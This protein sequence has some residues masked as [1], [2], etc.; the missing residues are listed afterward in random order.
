MAINIHIN[1]IS[2]KPKKVLG[3]SVLNVFGEQCVI[4]CVGS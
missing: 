2:P 3:V 4:D 1:V